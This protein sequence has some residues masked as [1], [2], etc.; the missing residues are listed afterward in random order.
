M[1]AFV[2]ALESET[3]R[4]RQDHSRAINRQYHSDG[5]DALAFWTTADDTSGTNV[6]DG[7]G[8][9]F[10]HLPK[11]GT[12]TADLIDASDHSTVLGNDI[13]VTQGA[14]A[15]TNYAI[16]WT[17][18]V[19]GSADGD[20]LVAYNSLGNQSMGIRGIIDNADPPLGDLQQLD[21]TTYAGF[22][23]AQVFGN[24]GTNR[25]LQFEDIQEVIDAVEENSEYKAADV[26]FLLSNYGVRRAY[27]ALARAE[28]RQ[29][30]EMTL[31]GGFK[32]LMFSGI[33]WVVDNQCRRNV[34]YFV[35]PKTMARFQ[36]AELDFFAKHGSYLWPVD[37]ED[38]YQFLL[39]EYSNLV[40]LSRN[41]N[42]LLEDLTEA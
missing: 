39:F 15:A 1:G 26:S 20:Y 5:T 17:G 31:D 3:D 29:V 38:A 27:Y 19:S 28:R 13:V 7:Q 21:S 9:A 25:Q 6:D 30:N 33:P 16:T 40:C 35:N 41:G 24:S 10:S 37:G 42:G 36:M 12:I 14:K 2:Q 23:Q 34:V 18:T 11:S 22:W 4:G 32:A 8:N